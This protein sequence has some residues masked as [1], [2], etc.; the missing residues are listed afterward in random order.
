MNNLSSTS[1]FHQINT[2]SPSGRL[3]YSWLL[4]AVTTLIFAGIFALMVALARTP[5]I[6]QYL[7]G[8]DY[9]YIC[10]VGH[11]DMAVIIWFLA[12]QGTL[13]VLTSSVNRNVP[14]FSAVL[15][16]AG[17]VCTA[18]G[19]AFVALTALFGLGPAI[20]V[21][22]IPLVEHPFFY[23]GLILVSI[24]M[25]ITL[26]NT[27]ATMAKKSTSKQLSLASFGMLTVGITL[28]VALICFSL[29]WYFQMVGPYKKGFLDHERLFWGGG[30]ILQFANAMTMV[31][32]WLMLLQHT[33][34]KEAISDT[35][36]KALFALYLPFV[37]FAPVIYFLG[38]IA[39]PAH[40]E[41][42]TA[43]MQWGLGW[44]T[45]AFLV[46]ILAAAVSGTGSFRDRISNLPWGNPAFASLI[47]SIIVFTMGGS[48]GL[49][50]HGVNVKI[51]AHYHG[52]VGGV[53]IALMGLAFAFITL[54]SRD[55]HLPKLARFQ[56]YVY[57][58]GLVLFATGLFI[59]GGHGVARK[60]YGAEQQLNNLGKII[61]MSIM[62]VGGIIAIVGG[63]SFV[64]VALISLARRIKRNDMRAG[65][66]NAG[67]T[68]QA[69]ATTS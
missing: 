4:F 49:F 54:L 15:G 69:E 42:F 48:I 66:E 3:F 32:A 22:Y 57:A 44:S 19:T 5:G 18:T 65:R 60:T 9:I 47:M 55:I 34:G 52:A 56:P 45:T 7:P 17:F 62:G 40:K 11:V 14:L 61:G 36:G 6:M 8:K 35:V 23:A 31:V 29:A 37:L 46:A 21:N 1:T 26:L 51:P 10:L 28:A 68:H 2:E 24:G 20:I 12:F 58:T 50:L 25:T 64:L 53:T 39:Q 13:L 63:A 41:Y 27:F 33:L 43:L 38:D 67:L 30:H 16:W 59:A